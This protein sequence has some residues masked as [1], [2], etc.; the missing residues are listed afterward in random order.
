MAL[1]LKKPSALPGFGISLGFALSYLGLIV[2]LPLSTIFLRAAH[3]S[4]GGFLETVSAPRVLASFRLSFGAALAGA[5]INAVF[6]SIAAWA[7]VRYR[8][9]GR[10]FLNGLVDLPFALPTAA[11]G[12][13][14]T[15]LYAETGWIGGMLASVGIKS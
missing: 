8:F 7:F 10:T 15:A 12:I 1:V 14:L 9:P 5:A 3:S 2:L 6:G 11:A 4:W 13:A